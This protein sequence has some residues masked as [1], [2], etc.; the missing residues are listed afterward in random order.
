MISDKNIEWLDGE[1]QPIEDLEIVLSQLQWINK[2]L[3]NLDALKMGVNIL[4]SGLPKDR[5]IRLID[6]G[7]GLVENLA[8]IGLFLEG[9]GYSVEL[10]GLDKNETIIQLAKSKTDQITFFQE[11]VLDAESVIP[12]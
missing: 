9:K 3:G 8:Q 1:N 6:I 7:C 11:D 5:P 10:L 4:S 2:Y 12:E